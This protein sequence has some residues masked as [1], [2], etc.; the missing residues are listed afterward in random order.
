MIRRGPNHDPSLVRAG[1]ILTATGIVSASVV[2]Q[3]VDEGGGSSLTFGYGFLLYLVLIL[4]AVP[5][6]PP[7]YGA[8]VAFLAF[9][10]MYLSAAITDDHMNDLGLTLYVA[11]AAL[12]Y[13]ATTPP[14]RPITIAAFAL[15]TPVFRFFGPDPGFG[16]YPP[17][18]AAATMTALLFLV[19]VLL[20]RTRTDP[21]ERIRRIGLGLLAVACVARITER[22]DIVSSPGL[23][24]PDDLWAFVVV[25]VLPILAVARLR[26]PARDALAT[27]V[28]LGAYVLVGVALLLGKGYHVDAVAVVH[29]A[30]E[31]LVA[32]QNPYQMLD[33]G[34]ALHHFGLDQVLATK[35]ED[36]S[37]L[38]TLNY[39]ALSFLVPAPFVAAGLRDIRFLY[40][41]EI[42]VLVLVLVRQVRV[43]WRPLIAAA[44]VGSS[45]ISRQN[46][47]AGV[48]P[49]WA[50][51]T[52]FAF[53]FFRRRTASPL[54]M[55][56]A[57]ATRQPA[58][59]FAP[60]YVL[61][62]WKREGRREALRRAAIAAVA[63]VLPN[64]PFLII[65]PRA[66]FDGVLAPMLGPL[67]PY[68][69]GLIRFALGGALPLLPRGVYGALSA[70]AMVVFLV[71]LWR[72]WRRLPNGTLVFPSAIL[73][74][75]W[76]S[77]QN[78]FSF[79]A[80]LAMVGDENVVT[81]EGDGLRGG[82]DA[83]L[84]DGERPLRVDEAAGG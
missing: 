31:L 65:A 62:A 83:T 75:A 41:G 7:R 42:V 72:L 55:G 71:L 68:G 18:L 52:I 76:R 13:V 59:F 84:D 70:S 48:D 4:I 73:W 49:L 25:A 16:A 5:R 63:G 44:V 33:V 34:E 60:F 38:H 61:A 39:P 6:H 64:L 47:L 67:E 28:A 74:F 36:G 79:A 9:A 2:R 45:V 26:R 14:F 23:I 46:V 35:L 80:V 37:A 78:Y 82:A 20:D 66:F 15:W 58:W 69:V 10:A 1:L 27:G 30:A 3:A 53:L 54:L 8:L 32:G 50:I 57:C 22:H 56:L 43:P 77:L 29:R 24:A 21:D 12:A 19:A 81:G 11:A 51:L 40:L 17:S